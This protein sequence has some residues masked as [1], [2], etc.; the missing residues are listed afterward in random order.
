MCRTGLGTAMQRSCDPSLT[1]QTEEIS[2]CDESRFLRA[3]QLSIFLLPPADVVQA[4]YFTFRTNR[5]VGISTSISLPRHL[6]P[7]CTSSIAALSRRSISIHYKWSYNFWLY[8][9]I[10]RIWS[11]L[12]SQSNN[13]RNVILLLHQEPSILSSTL[14]WVFLNLSSISL[15][16]CQKCFL[17]VEIHM[18]LYMLP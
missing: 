14:V 4:I 10:F 15:L 9:Q 11:L 6:C 1:Q 13:P 7:L 18:L 8:F 5:R 17:F 3:F 12:V 16:I 2:S